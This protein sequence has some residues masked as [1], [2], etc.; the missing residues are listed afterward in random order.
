M[1]FAPEKETLIRPTAA[2]VIHVVREKMGE[3]EDLC[4]KSAH[5]ARL[6]GSMKRSEMSSLILTQMRR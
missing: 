3:R 5:W 2:Y 6:L 4:V 1:P